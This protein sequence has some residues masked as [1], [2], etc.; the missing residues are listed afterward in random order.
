LALSSTTR[1]VFDMGLFPCGSFN[2][3]DP[4][5]IIPLWYW[6]AVWCL[7]KTKYPSIMICTVQEYQK[8]V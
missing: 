7:L 5:L 1:I 4:G 8:V 2:G 6:P 3:I